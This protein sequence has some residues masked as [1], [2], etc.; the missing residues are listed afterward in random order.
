MLLVQ[1]LWSSGVGAKLLL[2]GSAADAA[3]DGTDLAIPGH[4]ERSRCSARVAL[5]VCHPDLWPLDGTLWLALSKQDRGEVSVTRC[6]WGRWVQWPESQVV[7][8]GSYPSLC[9]D[10]EHGLFLSFTDA[11]PTPNYYLREVGAVT[12]TGA[13]L[14]VHSADGTDW[15]EPTVVPDESQATSSAGAFDAS[16]GLVLV[17]SARRD[18][19]WPLFARRSDDSGRTWGEPVMLT[20]PTAVTMRPDA[21]FCGDR[22]CVAFLEER[23]QTRIVC[24]MVLGPD[25]LPSTAQE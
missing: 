11:Q 16:H 19:G 9:G 21:L 2:L 25:D 14:L 4:N 15:S 10:T 22:L 17:Y 1:R 20:E 24:T 7:G 18:E 13:L 12:A 23:D 8:R 3:G 5:D 6:E